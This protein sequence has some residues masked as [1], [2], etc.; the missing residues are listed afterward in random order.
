MAVKKKNRRSI[1]CF[2]QSYIW[3]V[4][5]D[6]DHWDRNVLHI[7]S[8]DK[9]MILAYPVQNTTPYIVSIGK[10]FQNQRLHC[11]KRY[12]Y[13]YDDV[14]P[15][16]PKFVCELIDWALHGEGGVEVEWNDVDIWL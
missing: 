3:Y 2:N 5:E 15:I 14:Y 16:T 9:Q 12:L 4:C 11:W 7:I 8:P 1:Q 6:N 10:N 13:P